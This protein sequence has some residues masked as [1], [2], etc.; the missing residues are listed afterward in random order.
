MSTILVP[1]RGKSDP[2]PT[3]GPQICDFIETYLVFGP[4]DLRGQPARL[5]PEKRALIYRMY[6]I[7]PKNHSQSGRR[8]FKRCA[9]SLRKGTAKTELAAW[10]AAC[11]LHPD[12]PVRCIDWDGNEP[13]GAGVIDPYIPMVAYTEE[14]SDELAYGA[15]L[16]IL[17]YSPLAGDFE[18]GLTRIMRRN[19]DGKAVSLASS[20]DARDG[21]R[22]TFQ[23]FD[24]THRM[25]MPRLKAAHRTMLAN[26]PKRRLSDAWTLEITTAPAPGED[27]IAEDTMNYARQMIDKTDG[28][29]FFFHRQAPENLKTDTPEE[30]RTAVIEASGPT[31]EW[32]DIDT[33]VAQWSDPTADRAYLER[34]WLNRL[35]RSS[36]K[37]FDIEQ[38]K[39]LER[40]NYKPLRD[41]YITLGF[42]GSKWEDAT[43]IVATEVSTGFQ[44]M[45]GFWENEWNFSGW[46]V[47]TNEV[48]E[49]VD[50]VFSNWNVWRMYADPPYWETQVAKW[51]GKYGDKTV[52]EWWT[53]RRK[54]M[55]YAIKSFRNAISSGD[56]CHSGDKRLTKHIGNSYQRELTLRDEDGKFLTTIYKESP[57][58]P[59]KIDAAMASI[60]SWEARQDAIAAG[61]GPSIYE[62]RGVLT[63]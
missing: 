51:A 58:S 18:L 12:A 47:P 55:A 2:Y 10:L 32:S 29:L 30:I 42:D 61:V 62:E 53:N 41:E 25:N 40:S 36:S 24:E 31:A 17:E 39:L 8:R 5:D 28:Q 57:K 22:T 11:E 7:Y 54:P 4:G 33:I 3:L 20:P 37:A 16:T 60:L 56:I 9:I 1:K 19:G 21:A 15:L 38:W 34:V 44:W 13:V 26:I 49:V 23:L 63:I 35:V 45:P 6:E 48:E 50:F 27:S 59:F 46:K 52:I 43:A 14:Q